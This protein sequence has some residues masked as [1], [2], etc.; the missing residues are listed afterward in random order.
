LRVA[1]AAAARRVANSSSRS[2]PATWLCQRELERERVCV[3]VC[4]CVW[5]GGCE[6]ERERE[7]EREGGERESER[8]ND[9]VRAP[10]REVELALQTRHLRECVCEK[11]KRV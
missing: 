1:S 4:V 7:G 5:V 2:S 3:C 6:R 10:F 9:C 8:E 11:R